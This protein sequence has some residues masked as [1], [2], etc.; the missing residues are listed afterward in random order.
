MADSDNVLQ[1]TSIEVLAIHLG[2]MRKRV[3]EMASS[4]ATKEDIREL[5]GKLSGYATTRET[6]M[7]KVDIADLRRQLAEVTKQV[8]ESKPSSWLSKLGSMA[9]H[10]MA[11]VG[12]VAVVV[13]LLAN[14]VRLADA[15]PDVKTAKP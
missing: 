8:V 1:A 15:L 11:I 2:Y 13:S 6:E 9:T 4:M 5:E 10:L 12:V 7:L 3:D 14:G